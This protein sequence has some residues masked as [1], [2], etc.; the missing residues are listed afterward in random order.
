MVTVHCKFRCK[1]PWDKKHGKIMK[2]V[3]EDDNK[4]NLKIYA[5]KMKME[6]T[7]QI[8]SLRLKHTC[9]FHHSSSKVSSE[10]LAEKYLDDWRLDPNWKLKKFVDRVYKDIGVHI[11]YYRAWFSR[12]RAKLILYGDASDQYGKVHDYASAILEHNPGSTVVVKV[13]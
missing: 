8:K 13:E 3:C 9:S 4:C 1:C 7:F 5:V 6:E 12:A 2:C 11:G 10:W